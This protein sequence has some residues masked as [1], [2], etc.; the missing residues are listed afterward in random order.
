VVGGDDSA[1][2]EYVRV[3]QTP[4]QPGTQRPNFTREKLLIKLEL[5]CNSDR[6]NKLKFEVRNFV[7][8]GVHGLYGSVE[9]TVN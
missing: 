3:H 8:N 2:S 1:A 7:T 6:D 5:L 9:V 4:M